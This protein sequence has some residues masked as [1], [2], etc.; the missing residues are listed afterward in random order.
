M[1]SNIRVG[2]FIDETQTPALIPLHKTFT[3]KIQVKSFV[4]TQISKKYDDLQFNHIT[5][6]NYNNMLSK[7]I[8]ILIS[9]IL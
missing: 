3:D 9:I 7:D 5:G 2:E 8:I 4:G 6:I 1:K